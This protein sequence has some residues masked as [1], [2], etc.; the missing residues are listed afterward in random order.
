M[1]LINE[2]HDKLK[3]TGYYS[4]AE[5]DIAVAAAIECGI[6]VLIEGPAGAGKTAL[7]HAVSKMMNLPLIRVQF[8]EGVTDDKILYDF[9]YQKQLLTLE[10]V[11]PVLEREYATSNLEDAVSDVSKK[12]HFYGD[13]YLIKRPVLQSIDGTGRK[14]LLLDEIDK[15]PEEIEYTLLEVLSEFSMSIPQYGTVTC[16]EDQIPIVFLTS[17]KYRDLSDAL[18]RRCSYLYLKH[19]N[20]GEL[21]QIIKSQ[22]DVNETLARMIAEI[23]TESSNYNLVKSPSVAEGVQWARFLKQYGT[24]V[25]TMEAS[26]GMLFKNVSDMENMKNVFRQKQNKR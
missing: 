10:A 18:K 8:F 13:D 3:K 15:A 4:N 17:N 7:A 25:K 20:K 23:I 11:R 12:L 9:D 19:K 1:Y 5:T 6:P 16:P 24:D 22:A 21:M 26:F 14:V 2:I